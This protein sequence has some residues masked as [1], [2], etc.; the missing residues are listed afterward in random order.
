MSE[1]VLSKILVFDGV[2]RSELGRNM[3][4]QST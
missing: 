3:A 2:E 4:L 1:G